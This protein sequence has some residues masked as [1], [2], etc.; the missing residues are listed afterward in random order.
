MFSSLHKWRFLILLT[1]LFAKT[2]L[3]NTIPKDWEVWLWE[4]DVTADYGV[5]VTDAKDGLKAFAIKNTTGS[6]A[7]VKSDIYFRPSQ[8]LSLSCWLRTELLEGQRVVLAVGFFDAN[9]RYLKE[10]KGKGISGRNDWTNLELEIEAKDIPQAA[11][12]FNIYARIE[13][14]G[15]EQAGAVWF[16]KFELAEKDSYRRITLSNP[17]FEEDVLVDDKG[18]EVEIPKS[19]RTSVMLWSDLDANKNGWSGYNTFRLEYWQYFGSGLDASITL[20]ASGES[21]DF[22]TEH[23]LPYFNTWPRRYEINGKVYYKDQPIDIRF[24]SLTLDYSPYILTLTDD[25]RSY[26]QARYGMSAKGFPLGEH[27]KADAFIINDKQ[28]IWLGGRYTGQFNNTKANAVMLTKY[29][30]AQNID[31][32]EAY[33]INH[34]FKNNDT[35]QLDWATQKQKIATY[36]HESIF[37]GVYNHSLDEINLA[38]RRYIFSKNFSAPYSDQTPQYWERKVTAWNPVDRYRGKDGYGLTLSTYD[39]PFD[40][41]VEWDFWDET[42]GRRNRLAF[43]FNGNL[44]DYQLGCNALSK[45][46]AIASYYGTDNYAIE[47]SRWQ[48]QLSKELS[49]WPL[50]VSFSSEKEDYLGKKSAVQELYTTYQVKKG[51]LQGMELS[52]GLERFDNS[53]SVLNRAYMYL[54]W[55]MPNG[56][57]IKW[58]QYNK[59]LPGGGELFSFDPIRETS[60]EKRNSYFWLTVTFY[61]YF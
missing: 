58:K 4:A 56:I 32:Y 10:I 54:S 51:A 2:S 15:S 17:S 33:T 27:S 30:F 19:V 18:K 21:M 14:K 1:L 39:M 29:P 59:E 20:L 45:N 26:W 7:L 9:G 55:E 6:I 41:N 23:A 60:S 25:L 61:D 35:L 12:K 50:S 38:A 52:G 13:G 42:E 48:Y 53:L 37:Y 16:D 47:Y 34:K 49:S 8:G 22:S 46:R 28:R 44:G 11:R 40:A 3:A 43:D 5:E 24:G 31:Q 36:K 57:G